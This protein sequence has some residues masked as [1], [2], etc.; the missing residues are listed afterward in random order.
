MWLLDD[1]QRDLSTSAKLHNATNVG[2]WWS[3]ACGSQWQ[4]NDC[5]CCQW[6]PTWSVSVHWTTH[7]RRHSPAESGNQSSLIC[8][9]RGSKPEVYW[10]R[11]FLSKK[12]HEHIVYSDSPLVWCWLCRTVVK[13]WSWLANFPC[14]VLDLQHGWPLMCVSCPQ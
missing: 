7:S 3:P 9:R 2:D 6:T 8:Y 11:S 4:C 10:C 13:R 5:C 1:R 14:P 12:R